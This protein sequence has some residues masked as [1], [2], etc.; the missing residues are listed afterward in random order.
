MATGPSLLL[1]VKTEPVKLEL[2]ETTCGPHYQSEMNS[3]IVGNKV[4]LCPLVHAEFAFA[5]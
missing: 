1:S 3:C 2:L 4:L 5:Y